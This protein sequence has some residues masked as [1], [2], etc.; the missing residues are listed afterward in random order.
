MR[1]VLVYCLAMFW[2]TS[3][4]AG[5]GLALLKQ[6]HREVNSLQADFVQTVTASQ[7]KAV[8]DS[9]GTVILKR[10]DQFRWEYTKPF[11]QTIVSDGKTI[12]LYDSELEQVTIKKVE[13]AL[14]NAP[15]RVLSGKRPL[16]QDFTISEPNRK[17]GYEWVELVP[18]KQDTDFQVILVG[19]KDRKLS[20]LELKDNLGQVTRIHFRNTIINPS[21]QQK[22]FHFSIPPNVEVVGEPV[23]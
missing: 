10:P 13:K 11:P 9:S 20:M 18:R 12:W 4:L 2:S 6:F 8:Q 7:K 17:D 19:F 22:R 1:S 21:I 15:S 3:V 16:E 23:R 5:E 14:G